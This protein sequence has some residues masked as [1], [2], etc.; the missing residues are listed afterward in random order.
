MRKKLNLMMGL[1]LF[2]ELVSGCALKKNE[3]SESKK[4]DKAPVVT[5]NSNQRGGSFDLEGMVY[6]LSRQNEAPFKRLLC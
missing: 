2:L 4:E 5:Q 6:P 1:L 3:E